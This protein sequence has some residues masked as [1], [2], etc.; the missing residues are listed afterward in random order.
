MNKDN[1]L[2]NIIIEYDDVVEE[3]SEEEKLFERLINEEMERRE[4]LTAHTIISFGEDFGFECYQENGI[5]TIGIHRVDSKYYD[6]IKEQFYEPSKYSQYI[7]L[8]PVESK[9]KKFLLMCDGLLANEARLGV[10]YIA[11]FDK[12]GKVLSTEK[13]E[14]VIKVH[15]RFAPSKVSDILT[16]EEKAEYKDIVKCL[17]DIF[18]GNNELDVDIGTVSLEEA[19]INLFFGQKQTVDHKQNS[20]SINN[21]KR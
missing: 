9:E 16:S 7:G 21:K 1:N 11:T 6:K 10:S 15:K 19:L 4:D 17:V 12:T 13:K 14:S 2:E 20:E 3:K 5:F 8:S 18:N